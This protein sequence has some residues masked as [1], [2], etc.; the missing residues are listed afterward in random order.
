MR[1][2]GVFCKGVVVLD[3]LKEIF[4]CLQAMLSSFGCYRRSHSNDLIILDRK[5]T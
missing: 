2:Q 3:L 4:L 5:E 1:S